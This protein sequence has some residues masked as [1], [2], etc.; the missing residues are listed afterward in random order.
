MNSMSSMR[1]NVTY[2][3]NSPPHKSNTSLLG[4]FNV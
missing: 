1:R 3:L 2:T 4:S